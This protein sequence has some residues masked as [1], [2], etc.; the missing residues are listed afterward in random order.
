[1]L[2]EVKNVCLS[3][4]WRPPESCGVRL[5][6]LR[7][8]SKGSLLYLEGSGCVPEVP[9]LLWQQLSCWL[10][11][12]GQIVGIGNH[13]SSVNLFPLWLMK[14]FIEFAAL[15]R[16]PGDAFEVWSPQQLCLSSLLFALRQEVCV[17]ALAAAV[18]KAVEQ[19]PKQVSGSIIFLIK[20]TNKKCCWTTWKGGFC[21][22]WEGL[23]NFWCPRL[24]LWGG[25]VRG[26]S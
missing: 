21:H 4:F 25:W 10:A 22:L 3:E 12:S 15:L 13:I 9:K 16:L 1:M 5:P 23:C 26:K 14:T 17:F 2:S 20:E 8:R 24:L 7:F 19:P 18:T 11:C 6:G